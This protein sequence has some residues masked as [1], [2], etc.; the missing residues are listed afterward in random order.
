MAGVYHD[1]A[2]PACG[3]HF[4]IDRDAVLVAGRCGPG[5]APLGIDGLDL[6]FSGLGP[7]DAP[8]TVGKPGA[9]GVGS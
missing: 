5:Q 9:D 2:P 4:E 7:D 3:Q 6:L 8:I 1:R